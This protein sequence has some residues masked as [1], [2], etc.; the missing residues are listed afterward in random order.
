MCVFVS[1]C[2]LLSVNVDVCIGNKSPFLD[3]HKSPLRARYACVCV[4]G[5]YSCVYM[6]YVC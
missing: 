3:G 1:A 6:V 4:Y 2:M 5:V